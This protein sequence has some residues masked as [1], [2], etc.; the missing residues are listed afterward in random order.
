MKSGEESTHIGRS[1]TIH[2]ELSGEEDL[3]FDGTLEGTVTLAANRLT[4]GPNARV[5]A[6]L[7]V[8]DLVVYGV[9]D[10]N[11][12]AAGRIELRQSAV[13]N[14]DLFASRLSIEENASV[15]GRVELTGNPAAA[16]PGE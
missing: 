8:R 16:R 15:K 5:K 9:V 7:T 3:F 1:V 12:R 13:L 10:G 2:G 14:G 4:V 11:V 6:D